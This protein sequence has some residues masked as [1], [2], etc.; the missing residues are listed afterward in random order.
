MRHP[1]S[2]FNDGHNHCLCHWIGLRENLQ[3][4]D[5]PIFNDT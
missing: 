2:G 3:E 5:N 4:K 1:G